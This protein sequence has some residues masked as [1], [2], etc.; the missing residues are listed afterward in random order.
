VLARLSRLLLRPQFLDEL[1]DAQTP[2]ET[3]HLIE[4]AEKDLIG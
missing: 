1:R 3:F 2:G 4:S